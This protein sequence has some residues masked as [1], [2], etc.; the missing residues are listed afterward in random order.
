MF[1]SVLV[2]SCLFFCVLV[3]FC[4]FRVVSCPDGPAAWLSYQSATGTQGTAAARDRSRVRR[5]LDYGNTQMLVKNSLPLLLLWLVF[6]CFIPPSV[7]VRLL[8]PGCVNVNLKKI[9]SA[10]FKEEVDFTDMVSQLSSHKTYVGIPGKLSQY[11]FSRNALIVV[12]SGK[13]WKHVVKIY[14]SL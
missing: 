1:L 13:L 8:H 11:H 10:R 2:W 14:S 12:I 4:Q 9:A 5:T 3:C 6:L 7:Y